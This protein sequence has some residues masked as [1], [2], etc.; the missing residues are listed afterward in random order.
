MAGVAKIV[1]WSESS[2]VW[3]GNLRQ[4]MSGLLM[5]NRHMSGHRLYIP[6][7]ELFDKKISNFIF[8]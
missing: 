7:L 8:S 6:A 3:A 5:S 1:K 2:N 4:Q